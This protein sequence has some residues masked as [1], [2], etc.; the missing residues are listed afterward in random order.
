MG[1]GFFKVP[2]AVNEPVKS[3]APGSPEREAVLKAYIEVTSGVF[4]GFYGFVYGI[5]TSSKYSSS[6]SIS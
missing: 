2:K 4:E 6:E 3:Y 5:T 1:K